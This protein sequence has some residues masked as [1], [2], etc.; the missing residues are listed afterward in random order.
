MGLDEGEVI[1]MSK[2][3]YTYKELIPIV[4]DTMSDWFENLDDDFVA[5]DG[6]TPHLHTSDCGHSRHPNLA[7]MIMIDA[8]SELKDAGYCQHDIYS[9]VSSAVKEFIGLEVKFA[10]EEGIEPF[11]DECEHDDKPSLM[12]A[13]KHIPNDVN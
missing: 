11:S 2:K 10:E 9:A 8:L 1:I 3:T 12:E 7:V 6:L 5:G 13:L 4:T